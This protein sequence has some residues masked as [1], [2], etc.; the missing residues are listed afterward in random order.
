MGPFGKVGMHD[1]PLEIRAQKY[2]SNVN[3]RGRTPRLPPRVPHCPV[4]AGDTGTRA[5]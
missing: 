5:G 3:S 4:P 2:V 1:R